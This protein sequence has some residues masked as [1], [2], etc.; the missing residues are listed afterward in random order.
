M[1][2]RLRFL[3][4]HDLQVQLLL[5]ENR[6]AS[7]GHC[8]MPAA[9]VPVLM[10]KQGDLFESSVQQRPCLSLQCLAE[11]WD[12][13]RYGTHYGHFSSFRTLVYV[14]HNLDKGLCWVMRT[15]NPHVLID[16]F[17]LSPVSVQAFAERVLCF[18]EQEAS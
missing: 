5:Q 4:A 7:Q 18:A 6:V 10:R 8:W 14:F 2:K 13:G 15:A 1:M 3:L 12:I 17:Q 11:P 16:W 9:Q